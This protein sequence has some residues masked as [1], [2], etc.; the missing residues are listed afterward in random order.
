[1]LV[2][3]AGSASLYE[4]INII[5][6]K[7]D[8][9]KTLRCFYALYGFVALFVSFPIVLS[10]GNMVLSKLNQKKTNVSIVGTV[11]QSISPSEP[12]LPHQLSKRDQT[13]YKVKTLGY[14]IKST[15][16]WLYFLIS[17][18]MLGYIVF[19]EFFNQ[20]RLLLLVVKVVFDLYYW[21]N[22]SYALKYFFSRL[23]ATDGH[24]SIT[25]T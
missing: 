14:L 17:L 19:H 18:M 1:M 13:S 16:W 24:S 20:N 21:T 8:V 12:A 11:N 5:G 4:K 25:T 6:F 23:K 22:S 3:M 10:F 7:M 9:G 15:A 2:D